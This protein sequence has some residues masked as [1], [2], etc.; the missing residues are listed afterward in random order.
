MNTSDNI[1][2]SEENFWSR[3]EKSVLVPILTT[4]MVLGVLGNGLVLIVKVVC[5][6]HFQCLYWLPLFSLTL[7]DFLC[8]I[9]MICGSLLAVLSEGQISPWCEVVS[10]LKFTFITSSIGSIAILCVQRYMG[11]PS[12]GKKLSVLMAVACVASWCTGAIFGAVPVV[13]DWIKYD[14]AEMLC[15]VFWESSYSDMLVYI[16]CAF[17]ISIFIPFLLIL[18]CSILTCAGY[19][20]DSSSL[21]VHI[22][23]S[24][25]DLSSITPLLVILYLLCYAPF[26]ASELVLLGRLDLSPS[27]E[28]LR[29]LSSVMAYLDCGLNPFIYCTNKDFRKAVLILFWNKRRSAF[30]DPVLTGITRLEI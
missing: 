26:A 8:S 21:N 18:F 4:E 6:D 2:E 7:S 16:L 25:G 19:G 24:Q 9:L 27:P 14:P 29:S 20:K 12:K 11:I 3:T 23:S 15:A 13:Y 10:L 28:W 22:L 5:K 17:S 30:P 1:T